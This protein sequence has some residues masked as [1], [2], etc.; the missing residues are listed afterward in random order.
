MKAL[1]IGVGKSGKA[2]CRFLKHHGIHAVAYDANREALE[3]WAQEGWE[4]YSNHGVSSFGF[5]VLSPGV[6]PL[7]PIVQEGI[8]L[9]KE[10]IGEAE[11]ALRT[12]KQPCIAITGTNGKTTVTLLV[13]H[14]LNTAGKKAVA[15]G[16][17]GAPLADYFI[18]PSENEIAVVE[19]S[20]Y[21]LETLQAP[22]FTGGVIL[23]ITPDHLDRYPSM[24][25]YG[26]AKC[27]LQRCLQKGAPLYVNTSV[28]EDFGKFLDPG[29]NTFGSGEG[30]FL[31][32]DRKTIR[33]SNRVVVTLPSRFL[34]HGMHESE[35]VVAA[36]GLCRL[37][38]ISEEVFLKGLET[39]SKPAHRIEKVASIEG[40][41]YINDS[42]GTNI[43]ATLQAVKSVRGN[44]ILI[45]GGVDK[46]SPY[47]VWKKPFFGKVKEV[48]V[49]GQAAPKIAADL[50]DEIPVRICQTLEEAVFSAAELAKPFDTVL[51]SPGC[52]SF[53]MFRDYAERGER[54]KE[55]VGQIYL[56]RKKG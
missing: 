19:L 9:R 20:S 40:V 42:K 7:D 52:S 10:M 47:T 46:G 11:L 30:A 36:W 27:Q 41:D 22:V 50:G 26:R 24:E 48:I 45:A 39:F 4:I 8:R 5:L 13:E 51:L 37:F 55:C 18:H 15:L 1:V 3:N 16:N 35:N 32:T 21:Q 29:Y 33:E 23:N 31:W 6:P 44:V 25:A 53:D 12:A 14:I 17:V 54:F 49:I 38:G 43:D 2:A 28:V 56:R 34:T